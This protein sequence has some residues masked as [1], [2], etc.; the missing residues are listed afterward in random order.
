[1]KG[2]TLIELLI[3]IALLGA[4]A[5]GLLASIDP[6]EQLNKG[7][8]TGIR[9]S[10]EEF[11]RASQRY[12]ATKGQFAWGTAAYSTDLNAPTSLSSLTD[13]MA[14]GELKSQFIT[15][16]GTSNL[17]KIFVNYAANG[18]GFSACFIPSSKAF[19]K[20]ANTIYNQSGSAGT[21]CKSTSAG[22]TGSDCSYCL[23]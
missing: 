17:A 2:F 11:V 7:R 16:A 14:A 4:L 8:D 18:S 19:Q 12:Y 22:T 20:D 6:V 10:A 5:V 21:T 23:Q 15:Q 9:N 1:M 3:V 13:M